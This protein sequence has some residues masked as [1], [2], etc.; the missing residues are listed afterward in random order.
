MLGSRKTQVSFS[1]L[2]EY[3]MKLSMRSCSEP[4]I[5]RWHL[6]STLWNLQE[7]F[8]MKCFWWASHSFCLSDGIQQSNTYEYA[9]HCTSSERPLLS[10]A[11]ALN[12][13]SFSNF[14]NIERLSYPIILRGSLKKSWTSTHRHRP[15]LGY[16][17]EVE[18]LSH[19]ENFS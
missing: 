13:S 9:Q 4:W 7:W 8:L 15:K 1:F 5:Y 19:Y 11:K 14:Y 6:Q 10:G 18:L 16:T 2:P 3:T 12:I 17:G